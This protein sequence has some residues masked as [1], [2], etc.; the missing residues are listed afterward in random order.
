MKYM[1]SRIKII[2]ILFAIFS[3]PIV[4]GFAKVK[5]ESGNMLLS[6]GEEGK[7]YWFV[8]FTTN[9]KKMYFSY[10]FNNNCDH[11]ASEIRDAFKKYL[12]MNDYE[13]IV[14]AQNMNTYHDVV[15][16]NLIKRR[17]DEI[18]RMKQQTIKVVGVNF[19][20]TEK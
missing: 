14:G 11:C 2:I 1:K 15:K 10:V 13:S 9:E 6:Q 18:Y 16:E 19:T 17:D 4:F 8:T 7:A 12:I 20:Y 3:I 5:N